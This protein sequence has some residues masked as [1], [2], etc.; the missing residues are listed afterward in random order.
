MFGRFR[1]CLNLCVDHSIFQQGILLCI[2]INTFSMGIE[3]H[4]QPETLTKVVEVS[5]LV[6]SCIFTVEMLL[7]LTAYGFVQYVSDGFNVFDGFIVCLGQVY[8][9][10]TYT[11]F[12]SFLF[13]EYF[14]QSN[15]IIQWHRVRGYRGR[16]RIVCVENI[17][18]AEN[19]EAGQV[20]T[21]SSE[22]IDS[23]AE[24]NGQRCSILWITCFVHLY[25]QVNGES[26]KKQQFFV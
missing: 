9:P 22:A 14:I 11:L 21:K 3:Y 18:A 15:G 7:K 4:D 6:F 26:L 10:F 25:F 23:D 20:S 19:S 16:I 2:F 24:D 5:N 17:P 1:R 12:S 13:K 8:L